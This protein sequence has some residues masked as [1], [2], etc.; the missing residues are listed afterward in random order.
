MPDAAR[1]AQAQALEVPLIL[2]GA[3]A[4][5]E[6]GHRELFKE[7][8]TTTLVFENGAV[9]NLR[10]KVTVGQTIF[11]HNTQ[12]GREM[13]CNVVEAPPENEPGHTELQFT[14]ADPEF[15]Q[16]NPQQPEAGA[17]NPPAAPETKE[18]LEAPNEDNLAMMSESTSKIHL[19]NMVTPGK[20]SGQSLREELVPAHEMVP[21]SSA[22]PSVPVPDFEPAATTNSL[23][24]EPTG[25]QIDAALRQ[26]SGAARAASPLEGAD[27]LAHEQT[28]AEPARDEQKHLAA[29]MERDARLAKFAAFK[30][31]QQAEKIQRDATPRDSTRGGPASTPEDES[32]REP[33]PAWAKATLSDK[34]I[35]GKNATYATIGASALIAVA[36]VFVWHAMRDSFIHP[37]DAPAASATARPTPTAA[38]GPS[39]AVVA[40][41]PP[42]ATASP[43]AP[44]PMVVA[45]PKAARVARPPAEVRVAM[46]R[47]DSAAGTDAG[48]SR[49]QK[50]GGAGAANI[51]PARVLSQP[52]PT[53]PPWAVDMEVDGVVTMDVTIDENGNVAETK[54]LS[55]PRGL[56]RE[57]E[58]ALSLWEFIPAKSDGKPMPWHLTISVDFLPPPPPKRVP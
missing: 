45:T 40:A 1:V 22:A 27:A 52:Q 21:N 10:S 34:L 44:Q 25:E 15:W 4:V 42:A 8:A 17:Q 6:S 11:I 38:P 49:G 12:N 43:K 35:T 51:I 16:L 9:L 57:A 18:Q 53:L 23:P 14:T 3:K 33:E 32:T 13:L 48:R 7:N 24:T 55:G 30:E 28:G 50:Q 29:L 2:Q 58:R 47:D 20:E 46:N 36:L 31:K 26:M 39:P 56:Q 41:I 19:P 5:D 37:S 54:V